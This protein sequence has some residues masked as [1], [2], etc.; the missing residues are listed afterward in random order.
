MSRDAGIPARAPARDGDG[1]HL[2]VPDVRA[3]YRC[4]RARARAIMHQAGAIAPACALMVRLDALRAW[5]ARHEARAGSAVGVGVAPVRAP[6]RSRRG[7]SPSSSPVQVL[8]PGWW[9]R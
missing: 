1:E 7:R 2:W 4:S 3:R 8:E 9:R 6:Q 5:E